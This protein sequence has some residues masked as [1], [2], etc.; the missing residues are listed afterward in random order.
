MPFVEIYSVNLTNHNPELR[1]HVNKLGWPGMI[2]EPNLN[3]SPDWFLDFDGLYGSVTRNSTHSGFVRNNLFVA[4]PG[5]MPLE[6]RIRMQLVFEEAYGTGTQPEPW[7]VALNVSPRPNLATDPMVNVSC[8]FTRLNE[9][10]GYRLN[11]PGSLQRDTAAL[12][13]KPLRYDDFRR[14]RFALEHYFCGSPGPVTCGHVGAETKTHTT[15]CGRLSTNLGA[16]DYRI[17]SSDVFQRELPPN[18]MIGAIGTTLIMAAPA[19]GSMYVKLL[20]FRVW[21]NQILPPGT[22]DNASSSK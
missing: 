13:E 9:G 4:P 5:G 14:Y 16:E 1:P 2:A 17:F 22:S 19:I 8:Q 7:A 11:T 18:P 3:Q 10:E 15:G 6:S 12:L 21:L 20:S